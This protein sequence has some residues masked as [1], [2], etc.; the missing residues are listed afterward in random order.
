MISVIPWAASSLTRQA[1]SSA[2]P[3]SV[4]WGMAFQLPASHASASEAAS[5]ARLIRCRGSRPLAILREALLV[6]LYRA[7]RRVHSERQIPG[8]IAAFRD[9]DEYFGRPLREP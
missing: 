8:N 5:Q 2:E 6:E 1:I 9:L 4:V 3:V 7:L